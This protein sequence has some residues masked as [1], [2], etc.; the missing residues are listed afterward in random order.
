MSS[1]LPSPTKQANPKS[2]FNLLYLITAF[3]AVSVVHDFITYQ[4]QIETVPYSDFLASINDKK[5]DSVMI[6][7]DRI[8]AK[9][10]DAQKDKPSTLVTVKPDDPALVQRLVQ[11]GIR[12]E[13][14]RNS[15]L[16]NNLLSWIAPVLLMAGFWWF[17]IVRMGKTQGQ[18][19]KIGK[20]K[21]KIYVER[22]LKIRFSDVAGVPEAKRELQELVDF[23]KDPSKF[24]RLGGRMPKGLLLVGPPGTGKTLLARAVAGEAGVPFF[25]ING[26]EFVE[27]FVG[28]GAARV[29]DLFE[30]ARTQAPCIIFIDE[31]DAMGKAR[32]VSA[33]GGGA[34]DEKE[35]TLNQL[36]AE[37]DGFDPSQGLVL[38]AATNRPE[39][40]DPALLRSGR[41]DRQLMIDQPDRKGREEILK[42]H[43]KAV[44]S[45][46]VLNIGNLAGMTAG[47]SGADLANLVNE[48]TLVA[49]RRGAEKVQEPDFIAGIERLVGGLERRSRVLSAQEKKRVAYHEMGHAAVSLAL[50]HQEAVQKVSIIPRGI[51]ALGYTMKR[52]LEDRYL[53][54]R[55]ELERKMAALLA[56]R[57]SEQIFFK[58][59]STGAAD[60][61][62]KAT[63]IARAMVTRYGMSDALGLL[64]Y[65]RE[66]APLL[67]GRVLSRSHDYSEDTAR[68]I[69]HETMDIVDRAFQR[70]LRTIEQHREFVEEGSRI[71]LEQETL[72][73]AA[74]KILWLKSGQDTAR[75]V[76]ELRNS[77]ENPKGKIEQK[78]AVLAGQA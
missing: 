11:A 21:A 72:D 8:E 10:K 74:L 31:L 63:D 43:L 32:G 9:L 56:G 70:A 60:D 35:Q 33:I 36:L 40:L 23:L 68:A 44:Q 41:F 50:D 58:E 53:T 62:D 19:L 6:D 45:D 66:S 73:E 38:L 48:A 14:A 71:L 34:N 25:S 51:G 26:S 12:F 49:T 13:A 2:N 16:W 4:S 17:V 69:D 5:I 20:S 22:E 64:T 30:E 37:L 7:G 42:I 24:G 55:D 77:D 3:F 57:A 29:R 76:F 27:M 54:D 78:R 65:D 67:N 59:V 39:I 52:P 61:L 15:T 46:P 47:F 28:L 75:E 1:P 18:F